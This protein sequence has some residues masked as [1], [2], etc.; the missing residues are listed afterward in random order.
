MVE[1][2]GDSIDVGG[3]LALGALVRPAVVA[4][5]KVRAQLL[6]QVVAVGGGI[7]ADVFPFDRT[8]EALDEGAVGGAAPTV[9]AAGG[10]QRL[11]TG[12][13]V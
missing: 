7:E 9:V 8:P 12:E 11:F 13:A 3:R 10:Q 2:G 1:C 4:A 6:M 5:G